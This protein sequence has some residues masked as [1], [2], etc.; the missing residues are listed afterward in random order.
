MDIEEE[1]ERISWEWPGQVEEGWNRRREIG[2]SKDGS[3]SLYAVG[4]FLP[5]VD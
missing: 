5:D 1:R 2:L 4:R 3:S